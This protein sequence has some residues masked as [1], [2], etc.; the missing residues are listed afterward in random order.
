V[1]VLKLFDKLRKSVSNFVETLTKTELKGAKLEP[2]LW[3]FKLSLLENDVAL[4]V[5]EVICEDLKK[6]LE[7]VQVDRFSNPKELISSTLREILLNLLR[8]EKRV[9][10]LEMAEAMR[11]NKR[12]LVLV[13]V[14]INGSG[15][16]TT[17]AKVAHLLQKKG[18]TTLLACGDTFRAGSIEQLEIHAQRLGIPVIKHQYGSDAAS[19]V[20]DAVK[21]ARAQ[22]I[23]V[24]L[25]DTAGRMQTNKN[26]MEEVKK[27]IRINCPDLTIFV[28]D[29]LTGND[30]VTQAEE[31]NRFV[32]MDASIL[33]KFDADAKGGSSISI[34][35]VTKKPVIYLG[36]GQGY[37]DLIPFDP[38]LVV[39]N[40]LGN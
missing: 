11:T 30:A 17:I 32:S 37:D 19:V 21:H 36:N 2:N 31:F 3:D 1:K 9:D 27:V 29:S 18:Y 24:V 35:Y 12:P 26:L 22:G 40:I 33:T 14:G 39:K 23:H 5:A 7:G 25:A 13:F 16:T 8:T 4:P 15:K 20:Y 28:G 34:T 38:N 10:L 6:R